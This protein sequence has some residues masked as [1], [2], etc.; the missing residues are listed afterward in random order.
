MSR[1]DAGQRQHG[2]YEVAGEMKRI[3]GERVAVRLD[4]DGV[5][6]PG[7]REINDNR[8]EENA[9]DRPPCLNRK[10]RLAKPPDGFADHDQS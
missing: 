3:G 1:E 9:I 7:A 10:I 8:D 6:P 4:G 2:G 5:Q